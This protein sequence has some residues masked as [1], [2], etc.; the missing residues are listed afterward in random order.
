VTTNGE[1]NLSENEED[2]Q[3]SPQKAKLMEA[4]M[5]ESMVGN[6]PLT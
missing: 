5:P 2:L 3:S 1:E 4:K 6:E